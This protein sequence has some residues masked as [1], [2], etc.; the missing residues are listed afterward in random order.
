[1]ASKK[2]VIIVIVVGVIGLAMFT[3][4]GS[5]ASDRLDGVEAEPTGVEAEPTGVEAMLTKKLAD[6][7]AKLADAEAMLTK[8]LAEADAKLA[9]A[10]AKLAEARRADAK[11]AEADAKLAEADAKRTQA[12]A[13]LDEANKKLAEAQALAEAKEPTQESAAKAFIKPPEPDPAANNLY[14]GELR[15]FMTLSIAIATP[16]NVSSQDAVGYFLEANR[17]L[18]W[19]Y[20][21]EDPRPANADLSRF[22]DY[23]EGNGV[24]IDWAGT[25]EARQLYNGDENTLLSY[26]LCTW[27][28]LGIFE[29]E[30]STTE[31]LQYWPIECHFYTWDGVPFLQDIQYAS[32]KGRVG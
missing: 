22:K 11:L 29:R 19:S 25:H 5:V 10:D 7:E 17:G 12:T 32:G 13:Q 26:D 27:T 6:A 28:A 8:K 14:P 21:P 18:G 23:L 3:S 16:S 15:E 9:E 24:N 20:G 30:V 4:L 31:F 1:M 2:I